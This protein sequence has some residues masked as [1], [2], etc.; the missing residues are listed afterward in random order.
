VYAKGLRGAKHL[1]AV[2]PSFCTE[3]YMWWSLSEPD[4]HYRLM[5]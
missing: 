3:N 2:G 1:C 4:G 5:E